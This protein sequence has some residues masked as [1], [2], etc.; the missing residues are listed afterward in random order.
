MFK[1]KTGLVIFQFYIPH[2]ISGYKVLT[3]IIAKVVKRFRFVWKKYIVLCSFYFVTYV[4]RYVISI[5]V[6]G[7]ATRRAV[8]RELPRPLNKVFFG[9]YQSDGLPVILNIVNYRYRYTKNT[10]R[11][12][13]YAVVSTE[14]V[15]CTRRDCHGAFKLYYYLVL[16]KI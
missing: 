6:T 14:L 13:I 16:F 1:P 8:T 3:L 2:G 4:G 5:W 12:R 7:H 9:N 11:S 10:V 15:L